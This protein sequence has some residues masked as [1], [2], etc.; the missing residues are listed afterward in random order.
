MRLGMLF[1]LA[2]YVLS[3][4]YRAFLAVLTPVLKAEIGV[5]PDDL[6]VS[7]GLFFVSFALMQLAVGSGL[8]R[9]GPRRTAAILL[10]V[11]GGGGAALFA[12]A[13]GPMALHLA[14]VL[15]G[16][17]CS[18]VLMAAY[19]IFARSFSPKKFGTLAGVMVGVGSLGNIAGATP[20]AWLIEA[21]GWR[22][23]LWGLAALTL[24]VSAA[25]A[26][27]VRDPAR[28]AGNDQDTGS[29]VEVLALRAL[30]PVLAL[31]LVAYAPAAVIRGAVGRA[32]PTTGLRCRCDRDWPRDPA[33][34]AGDGGRKFPAGPD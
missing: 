3:Q 2:A 28:V 18:P 27:F 16:I 4:F 19:F 20:L 25:L 11:G 33:D 5:G 13:E 12:V 10:A 21:A 23:T 32:I 15:I 1:L 14:M 17:G 34:G 8:D 31:M 26:V 9:F 30:W 24:L 29:F 7:S 22:T 6:A